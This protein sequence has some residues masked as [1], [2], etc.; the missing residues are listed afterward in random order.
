MALRRSTPGQLVA[1]AT[2]PELLFY[3]GG[4]LQ[5]TGVLL[6]IV[7]FPVL[8]Q[9]AGARTRLAGLATAVGAALLL[10]VVVIEAALLDAV[11][12]AAAAGDQ[13]TVATTFALSNGVFARIFPLAPA[14]PVFAGIVFA[15]IGNSVVP[16]LFGHSA[17]VVAVVFVPAGIAAIRRRL[18]LRRHPHH[19]P[20]TLETRPLARR[21]PLH[22]L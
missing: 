4:W 19:R 3:A 17:L 9:L 1:F 18:P 5:V 7:F 6:S 10:S 21:H 11:P 20:R 15:L 2:T 12:M 8:L 14:P 16:P 22:R 13:A